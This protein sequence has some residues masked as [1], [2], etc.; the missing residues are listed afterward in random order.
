MLATPLDT[1]AARPATSGTVTE[2]VAVHVVPSS[3]YFSTRFGSPAVAPLDPSATYIV[4]GG[5]EP[6]SS[7]TKA[8]SSGPKLAGRFAPDSRAVVVGVPL[9]GSPEPTAKMFLVVDSYNW[10]LET[11]TSWTLSVVSSKV[12]AVAPSAVYPMP[13]PPPL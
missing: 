3:E 10:P 9:V 7:L 13:A 8:N 12:L 4:S 11:N 1:V 5:P 2:P 6:D